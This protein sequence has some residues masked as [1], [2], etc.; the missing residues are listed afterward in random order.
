M[1]VLRA[2]DGFFDLKHY[3]GANSEILFTRFHF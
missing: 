1:G 3:Y 2:P